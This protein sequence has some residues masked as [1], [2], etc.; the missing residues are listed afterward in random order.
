MSERVDISG[1]AA[2]LAAF[3]TLC[4]FAALHWAELVLD[5]PRGRVL[6]LVLV[7]TAGGA[8]LAL[9]GALDI[10]RRAAMVALRG[11]VVLVMWAGA[12][13]A[14]G[15]P[16]RYARPRRYDDLLEGVER[17]L[18]AIRTVTWPYGA[19]LPWVRLTIL[20]G[21]PLFAVLAAALA[22]W[23]AGRR[24][25]FAL[26]LAGLAA[27]VALFAIPVT[28]HT[29]SV[30]LQRGVILFGLIAAWL[31]LP[32][33]GRAAARP[34]IAAVLAAAV[35]ALPVAAAAEG[36]GAWVDYERWPWFGGPT[37]G[38]TFDWSHGYGP[39]DW[40]RKGDTLLWVKSSAPHYWKVET[41]DRFD[42]TRWL[43]SGERPP[44]QALARPADR[45]LVRWNE[46]IA[47]TV[48]SLSSSRVVGAGTTYRVFAEGEAFVSG[49][50]PT[51]TLAEPLS[52]GDSYD[53]RAY[54][55]EP[56]A[57]ELRAAPTQY[58]RA[59]DW[60]TRLEIPAEP[61]VD[62]LAPGSPAIARSELVDPGLLPTRRSLTA[63]ERAA[64]R[65][66]VRRARR[67]RARLM[68]SPY[69]RVLRR[70]R[71]FARGDAS[72]Y[73]V[74][75]RIERYLKSDRF[76]YSERPPVRRNALAAF[77]LEDRL[78]YC[79]QFS[80]A[81]ALLLRM[82]GIPARVAAGFAPG[83]LNKES[84]EYR[85]RDLD[86]HSWVEVYFPE[87]GWVP[88]DPTPSAAPAAAQTADREAEAAVGGADA[89]AGTAPGESRRRLDQAQSGGALGALEQPRSRWRLVPPALLA[90]CALA[91]FGLWL[92][93]AVLRRRR[94]D[95][96]EPELREL[97]LALGRLGYDVPDGTT[98]LALERR[99]GRSA[100][101]PAARYARRLR[102]RRYSP[103]GGRP[104][105]RHERRALRRSLTA[106]AGPIGRARGFI[107]LPPHGFHAPPPA[108]ERAGDRSRRSE[109]RPLGS[110]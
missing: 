105:D 42:G 65:A 30:E 25:A 81:M 96:P 43:H 44:T 49:D 40:P 76:E 32:R 88:F 94:R 1:L 63:A 57:R 51:W 24:S 87:I 9:T 62:S 59:F 14:I 10:R 4:G 50:G 93:A 90:A 12:L 70:A 20:L 99:L 35:L 19:S 54:V 67:G 17:G 47:V 6:V 29:F 27:L 85:V 83:A 82:N 86:A 33:L 22:F 52:P 102:E 72:P 38:A 92:R 73:V 64:T 89:A 8:A 53:F 55:P 77:L 31:W 36:R 11:A 103:R 104:P 97:E 37:T 45:F 5:P 46:S 61:P 110:G 84:G 26:R 28:E 2:R 74:A 71:R 78:G 75:R 91:V 21:I 68:A 69:R 66:D 95:E 41:L 16:A 79:Q 3:A 18:A 101:P 23:P 39:I 13:A 100:G 15:L 106:R 56:S 108:R 98:L 109:Q 34:A 80:G 60:Y 7:V 107:A 58:E 48:R